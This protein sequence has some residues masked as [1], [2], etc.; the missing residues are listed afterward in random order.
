METVQ[1]R[2]DNLTRNVILVPCE[3]Q[4][5]YALHHAIGEAAGL[6]SVDE[7]VRNV[8]AEIETKLAEHERPDAAERRSDAVDASDV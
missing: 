1:R 2:I 3:A 6:V 7:T 5:I 8:I 4:Q